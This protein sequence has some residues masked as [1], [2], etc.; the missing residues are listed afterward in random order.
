VKRRDVV[1]ALFAAVLLLA[2]LSVF[3]IE[4]SN[5]QA[6]SKRDVEA[7]VH[8]R[9]VLAAALVDGLFQTVTQQIPQD[10]RLYGARTVSNR[11]M[12][13]RNQQNTYLALLDASG[14][15]VIASSRGFTAQARANLPRS[16]ALAPAAH[17]GSETCC[18]TARP[19]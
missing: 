12:D 18:R 2:L 13:V 17:T 1:L 6:K 19:G 3:A 8:E 5:T 4:L 11:T 10:A 9:G 14:H 15:R 16:A 7:R